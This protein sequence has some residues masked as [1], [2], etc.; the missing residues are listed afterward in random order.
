MLTEKGEQ[1]KKKCRQNHLAD[2]FLKEKP[3]C[4]AH[5]LKF[6]LDKEVTLKK[7]KI[8]WFMCLK[9]L[10]NGAFKKC[11][12]SFPFFP[13]HGNKTEFRISFIYAH[14]SSREAHKS[15]YGIQLLRSYL[16][17]LK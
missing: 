11:A 16:E 1:L 12:F 10:V 15:S 6:L 3:H 9:A 14:V 4:Y 13:L 5:L 8:H 2:L 7:K 17:N